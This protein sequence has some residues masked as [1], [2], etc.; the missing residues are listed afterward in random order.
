VG[1]CCSRCERGQHSEQH[2]GGSREARKARRRSRSVPKSLEI[3]IRAVDGDRLS[4]H[5]DGRV[6]IYRPSGHL[7]GRVVIYRSLEITIRAVDGDR[8]SGHLYG[9]VVIY[10]LSGHLYGRVVIYRS[11]EIRIRAVGPDHDVHYNCMG[12]WGT[13]CSRWTAPTS[14][15]RR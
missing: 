4:G 14:T 7:Y 8:L 1:A 9:R 10:R 6:V 3:T 2:G 13:C 12:R 5:L 11:L 15:R